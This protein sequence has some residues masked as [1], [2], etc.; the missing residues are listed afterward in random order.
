M[1][2]IKT[3]LPRFF[4]DS[5]SALFLIVN[6]EVIDILFEFFSQVRSPPVTC[7]AVYLSVRSV[8]RKTLMNCKAALQRDLQYMFSD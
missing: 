8:R 5:I 4:P 1:L 2:F 3:P 7:R 6:R